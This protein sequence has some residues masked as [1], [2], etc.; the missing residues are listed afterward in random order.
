MAQNFRM[1][2]VS[3]NKRIIFKLQGDVDGSS[4]A[5]ILGALEN[6]QGLP[7][8]LD[9]TKVRK[10][11]PFGLNI[12]KRAARKGTVMRGLEDNASI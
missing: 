10:C 12:L 7:V 8:T 4:A 9:F 2:V 5:L 11:H 3:Q 6:Y 1:R